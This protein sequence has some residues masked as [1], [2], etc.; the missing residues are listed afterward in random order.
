MQ[1]SA[2]WR[3]RQSGVGNDRFGFTLEKAWFIYFG[4]CSGLRFVIAAVE[5][6]RDRGAVSRQFSAPPQKIRDSH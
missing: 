5:M 1:V 2:G 3:C 4:W 6:L